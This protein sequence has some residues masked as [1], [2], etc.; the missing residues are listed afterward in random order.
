MNKTILM[1]TAI[2]IS[3]TTINSQSSVESSVEK[4]IFG[5]QAGLFG[6]F[7]YNESKLSNSIA[8]RSEIGMLAGIWGGSS[9]P[10]VGYAFYPSISVEPKYYYNLK[11]RLKKGKSILNNEGNYLSLKVNYNPNLFVI[12]N[13]SGEVPDHILITPSYGLR[14][15]FGKH[16]E[17]EFSTGIGYVYNFET[18]NGGTFLNLGFR[19]GYR[20]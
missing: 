1:L 17:Y 12:S 10:K 3:I 15:T 20:F 2:F 18:K 11:R 13:Y 4:S 6:A 8:L 16:F 5:V 7:A 14:R 19:I 9:Y